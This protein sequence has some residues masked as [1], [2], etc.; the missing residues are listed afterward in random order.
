MSIRTQV[1]NFPVTPADIK[2]AEVIYDPNI[3]GVRGKTV[4][5]NEPA[6]LVE[7]ILISIPEKY[8]SVTLGVDIF[9]VNGIRF[10]ITVSEHIGFGTAEKIGDGKVSTLADSLDTLFMLYKKEGFRVKIA[11][12]D[13]QFRP[14]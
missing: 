14:L 9:Y 2:L 8:R 10:F 7:N 12:M 3:G 6:L 13:N 1:K 5:R 4:C 11:L